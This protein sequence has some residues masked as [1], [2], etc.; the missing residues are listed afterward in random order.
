MKVIPIVVGSLQI[1]TKKLDKFL[2]ELDIKINTSLQK[3]K[4]AL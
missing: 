1:V 4:I 3:K 2:E